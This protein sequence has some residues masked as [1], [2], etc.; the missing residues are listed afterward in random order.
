MGNAPTKLRLRGKPDMV[1]TPVELGTFP[2]KET[3][4][5]H[6]ELFIF[7]ISH[8]FRSVC[9][10]SGNGS[11]KKTKPF[12]GSGHKLPRHNSR[13]FSSVLLYVLSVYSASKIL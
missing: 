2:F 11:G 4:V 9:A 8:T 7:F 10:H 12:S 13:S 5:S 1:S 3:V 6:H